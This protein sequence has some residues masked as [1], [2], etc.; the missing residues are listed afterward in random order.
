LCRLF[1]APKKIFESRINEKTLEN[2]L[3]KYGKK[4]F[5]LFSG[6]LSLFA[7]KPQEIEYSQWV[8]LKK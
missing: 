8:I 4:R 7:K 6:N 2:V 5:F 1:F 3:K